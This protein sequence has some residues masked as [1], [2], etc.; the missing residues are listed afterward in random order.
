MSRL[1]AIH[2]YAAPAAASTTT[3]HIKPTARVFAQRSKRP[4]F[5]ERFDSVAPLLT[6]LTTIL[7]TAAAR[8]SMLKL[9]A[10]RWA[11]FALLRGSQDFV[12]IQQ[13]NAA[14]DD[15]LKHGDDILS[16]IV[17]DRICAHYYMRN[18]DS[19]VSSDEQG[20]QYCSG[21]PEWASFVQASLQAEPFPVPELF[22]PPKVAVRTTDMVPSRQ[23][24]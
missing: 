22:E 12:N 6:V 3:A 9:V 8:L 19:M 2:W 21:F 23:A 5:D 17:P 11:H 18:R 24:G 1:R 10:R 20:R 14:E 7:L 16:R 15:S 13:V 4:C